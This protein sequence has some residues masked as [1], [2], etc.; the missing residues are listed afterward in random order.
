MGFVFVRLDR[1]SVSESSDELVLNQIISIRTMSSTMTVA[2]RIMFSRSIL[3][4]VRS[5]FSLICFVSLCL[6]FFFKS[7]VVRL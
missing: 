4:I 7:L 5:M 1:T 6:V 2:V 3:F